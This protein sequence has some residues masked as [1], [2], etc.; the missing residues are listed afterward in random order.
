MPSVI[1]SVNNNK[2]Y[3]DCLELCVLSWLNMGYTPHVIYVH[4]KQDPAIP[5]E[6]QKIQK[7]NIVIFMFETLEGYHTAF[8]AQT[9]RLF[10]PAILFKND[11]TKRNNEF[12][13]ISDCDIIPLSQCIF[14]EKINTITDKNKMYTFEI[15]DYA[16]TK[17]IQMCYVFG[18]S[19]MFNKVFFNIRT[20][21]DI[22]NI[23]KTH[24]LLLK[25]SSEYKG[26]H[27]CKGW[28][29]DQ[30][31]LTTELN[32]LGVE[33]NMIIYDFSKTHYRHNPS[34]GDFGKFN[35][36]DVLQKL[37]NDYFFDIHLAPWNIIEKEL[38]NM[39]KRAKDLFVPT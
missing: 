5:I 39:L 9:I 13:L 10:Y 22:Y 37:K 17:Q 4:S 3:L 26:G 6:L 34:Y 29:Y 18:T 19:V 12:I 35:D 21:E 38:P 7:L 32:K 11:E 23:Y 8:V 28:G 24:P 36:A 15:G 33:K 2:K 16:K 31:I 27:A 30:T 14:K 25:G 1:I 20:L